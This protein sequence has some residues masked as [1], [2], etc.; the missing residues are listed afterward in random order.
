ME[1][2]KTNDLILR[3]IFDVKM[4]QGHEIKKAYIDEVNN[5]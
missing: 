3:K 2:E 5:N 1:V 4:K